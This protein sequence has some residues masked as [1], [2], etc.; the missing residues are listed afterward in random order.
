MSAFDDIPTTGTITLAPHWEGVRMFCIAV[1]RTDLPRALDIAQSMGC[2]APDLSAYG[3]PDPQSFP[4]GCE[5]RNGYP[6]RVCDDGRAPSG[7]SAPT[8]ASPADSSWFRPNRYQ[9]GR[10]SGK[11][12]CGAM[13]AP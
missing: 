2:E 3:A 12:S 8:L 13:S 4:C 9:T 6:V 10:M 1:A 5:T 7:R 11:A